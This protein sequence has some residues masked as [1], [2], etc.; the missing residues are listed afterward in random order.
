[1]KRRLGLN[2]GIY[3]VVDIIETDEDTEYTKELTFLEKNKYWQGRA[4]EYLED[5][6]EDFKARENL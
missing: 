1:M 6:I 2:A 4:L 5:S 3:A